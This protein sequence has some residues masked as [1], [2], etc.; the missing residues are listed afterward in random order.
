[1]YRY[2]KTSRLNIL[3]LS[4]IFP[5]DIGGPANFVPRISHWLTQRGHTVQLVC[6]SD[7]I[8]HDDTCYP[9]KVHRILRRGSRLKRLVTT[10]SAIYKLGKSANIVFANGLDLETRIAATL[11]RKPELHKVVGDRAWE[12]ARVRKWYSGTIDDYQ[13]LSKSLRFRLLDK[14]RDT[15]L[16]RAYLIITPSHY[17]AKIVSGWNT[18]N[19]ALQIIYNS[20][21]LDQPADELT[22]P[23]Y[24]GKTITT[25]CRLVP[26]KGV[27]RL[28][29]A[30]HNLPNTRLVIAGEGPEQAKL[31]Q[32]AL[33]YGIADRVIFL[34]QISKSKVRAL[35][36]TSDLFILNSS[37]EGLPHV[38][39]EAMAARVPVIATDV[40]GTGEVVKHDQT[41]L[42]VTYGDDEGLMNAIHK[43]LGNSDT[44][45]RLTSN[46]RRMLEQH[47]DEEE[48]FLAYEN[49]LTRLLSSNKT[50]TPTSRHTRAA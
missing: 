27:D 15:S 37:Y 17:L 48:C 47:F 10:I 50:T 35:L 45:H 44:C 40:G 29:E 11:L 20:T 5:P 49:A 38:V 34:G 3:I 28:I 25:V 12:I 1:M 6:W 21:Q 2:V 19:R 36:E 26:W 23:A 42:L 41:G 16:A 33:S 13:H 24:H 4:G 7:N 39:L 32:Q 30:L 9:F 14:L 46:A 8:D 22:L 31:Q 18:N 43:L